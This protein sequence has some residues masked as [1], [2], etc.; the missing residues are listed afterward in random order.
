MGARLPSHEMP[1]GLCA[2]TKT[3]DDLYAP[4]G[5]LA[6]YVNCIRKAVNEWVQ[7]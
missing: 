7:E 3:M 4:N 2:D 6:P 5:R 1:R